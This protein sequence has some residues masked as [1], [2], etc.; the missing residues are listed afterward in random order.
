MEA[1]LQSCKIKAQ[2]WEQSYSDAQLL[3]R[4][5]ESELREQQLLLEQQ[6]ALLKDDL[7][8]ARKERCQFQNEMVAMQHQLKEEQ[9]RRQSSS[10]ASAALAAKANSSGTNPSSRGLHRQLSQMSD[11]VSDQCVEDAILQVSFFD[12]FLFFVSHNLTIE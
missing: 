11:Y 7:E 6:I 10:A 8:L 12:P 4:R 3:N 1:E 2:M 5:N 9:Q